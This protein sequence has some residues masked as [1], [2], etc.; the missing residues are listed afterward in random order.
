MSSSNTMLSDY[1]ETLLIEIQNTYQ[2]NNN[3]EMQKY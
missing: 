2:S 3:N 1:S